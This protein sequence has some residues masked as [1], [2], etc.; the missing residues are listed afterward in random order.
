SAWLRTSGA[1]F[2]RQYRWNSS[3]VS[4]GRR[5]RTKTSLITSSAPRAQ[6]PAAHAHQLAVHPLQPRRAVPPA[7]EGRIEEHAIRELRELDAASLGRVQVETLGRRLR[8]E[9]D[10]RQCRERPW[11]AGADAAPIEG[12]DEK[13]RVGVAHGERLEAVEPLDERWNRA[14]LVLHGRHE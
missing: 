5:R 9:I 12:V 2:S 6:P 10:R 13:V 4:S 7:V 8:I 1:C 11:T 14:V 3:R